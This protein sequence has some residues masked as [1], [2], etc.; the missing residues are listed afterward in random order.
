MLYRPI[1]VVSRVFAKGAGNWGSKPGRAILKTQ[2][3]V[4]DV[5]LLNT[6]HYKVQIK[7]KV[8]QSLKRSNAIAYTS[9]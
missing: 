2:K 1:G 8:E 6:H 7:N 4:P 5:A 3:M 9:V